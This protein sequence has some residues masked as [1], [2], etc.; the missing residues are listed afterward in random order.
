L[1]NFGDLQIMAE[2]QRYLARSILTFHGH[3]FP[4]EYHL[5]ALEDREEVE[6]NENSNSINLKLFVFAYP[7]PATKIVNF[8]IPN[9][10]QFTDQSIFIHNLNGKVVAKIPYS[11]SPFWNAELVESGIYFYSIRDN[12]GSH[13]SGKIIIK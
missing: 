9:D 5:G 8:V 3:H 1:I 11:K 7:N 12:N 6:N 13:H 4:I 10:I 2:I